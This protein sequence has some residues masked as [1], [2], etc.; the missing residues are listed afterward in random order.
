MISAFHSGLRKPV[1][2]LFFRRWTLLCLLCQLFALRAAAQ[3]PVVSEHKLDNGIKL[4]L[5]PRPGSSALHAAW[6]I[7]CGKRHPS[8]AADMPLDACFAG[9]DASN[10]SGFWINHGRRGISHGR[11][12]AAESLETWG[13]SE[14]RRLKQILTQKQIAPADNLSAPHRRTPDAMA[15]LYSLAPGKKKYMADAQKNVESQALITLDEIHDSANKCAA[16]GNILLVVVG[17][18]E[19]AAAIRA[20]EASFGTWVSSGAAITDCL[21]P[22]A[23]FNDSNADS[24]DSPDDRP[25]GAETRKREISS[26]K[27]EVLT[28]WT[29]QP[30]FGGNV[31]SFELFAE[32]LIGN[33]NSRLIK[34]LVHEQGCADDV[35]IQID[36]PSGDAPGLFIIRAVVAD[37]HTALEAEGV[38]LSEIQRALGIERIER[39]MRNMRDGAKD[40]S[41]ISDIEISR[42]IHRL[43]AK[44]ALFLSDASNLAAALTD[45][46]VRT[47]DW[48]LAL[49][50]ISRDVSLEPQSLMSVLRSAIKTDSAYS[51]LAE[52]D[53]I[54]FPRSQEHE[55]LASLLSKLLVNNTSDA[56][57]KE[58]LVKETLRQY[59]Q[60][61]PETRRLM[62][63]LIEARAA[64]KGPKQ[65][66]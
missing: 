6:F 31:S 14:S 52:R 38:I 63:S 2:A 21:S 5:A 62:L 16:P 20:M 29:I 41:E 37:G 54:R 48:R 24:T 66:D 58:A 30:S 49:K 4:L 32:L 11:D 43:N 1:L 46:H 15:E 39:N 3:S 53:P 55:R 23:D 33:T 51:I 18:V 12:I 40:F 61:P 57:A 36:A 27:S 34:Q 17:D 19:E 26:A 8:E 64:L 56:S 42:A 44:R 35:Q 7:D 22:S 65:N 28:A 47:G 45:A 59:G 9:L 13:H 10:A 60:A 50:Q 25:G